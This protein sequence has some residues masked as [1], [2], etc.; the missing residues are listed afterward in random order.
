MSQNAFSAIAVLA[1]L[2]FLAMAL[3]A[4]VS[5]GQPAANAETVQIAAAEPPPG[6]PEFHG[7]RIGS[8]ALRS[9]LPGE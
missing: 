1:A 4:C 8:D 5:S 7:A 3:T 2:T 9:R 6:L